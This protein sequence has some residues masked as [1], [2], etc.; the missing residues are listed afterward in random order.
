MHGFVVT[1]LAFVFAKR[2]AKDVTDKVKSM[3]HSREALLSI[4]ADKSCCAIAVAN[5]KGMTRIHWNECYIYNLNSLVGQFSPLI[6]QLWT[7]LSL[8][9]Y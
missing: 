4:S 6:H 5:S 7:L 8:E 3:S 1:S 9:L 2:K